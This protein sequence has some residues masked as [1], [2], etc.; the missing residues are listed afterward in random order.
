MGQPPF[1]ITTSS[2]TIT[3]SSF[4]ITHHHYVTSAQSDHQ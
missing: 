4:T 3:T 2:F 1:T